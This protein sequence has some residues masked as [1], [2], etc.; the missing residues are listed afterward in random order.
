MKKILTA[1]SFVCLAVALAYGG[2][3]H[4]VGGQARRQHDLLIEQINRSNY[5]YVSTK[6]Y[7]RG[8]FSSTAVTTVTVA[9][10]TRGDPIKFN[11]INS[12]Q[13]G[14]L[15]YLESPHIKGGVQRVVAVIRTRLAPGDRS[16]P[17][18][19]LLEKIPDLEF[20]EVL[21][22]IFYDGSGESY[23]DVPSFRKTLSNDKGADV[24]VEWGGFTSKS[25]FDASLGE[26]SGSYSAPYCQLIEKNRELHVKDIQCDFNSHPGIKGISV[27]SMALSIGS[28]DAAGEGSPPFNLKSFGMQA[29]SG[30]SGQT[31][32]GALRL[33]FDKLNASGLGL[34]PFTVEFEA[35]KLD[36]D[37]LSRFERL[38]Q[39]LRK[40]DDGQAHDDKE[41]LDLLVR[42]ILGDLLAKSPEFEIKQLKVRTDKG[43]MSGRAG[44]AFNGHG[45]NSAVNIPALLGRIDASADLTVSEALFFLIA[46]NALRDGSAPH[47]EAEA[48]SRVS[49][50]VNGL[51]AAKIIVR[52]DGAFKSSATYRDGILTVN[53]HKLDLSKLL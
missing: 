24:D 2:V 25:K 49:G 53:G 42:D 18:K 5:L 9:P 28:I 16:D 52:E 22:V 6:S 41:S 36:A 17:L 37:V 10:S 20:S 44:L 21:T 19:K 33:G 38:A 39:E 14:P 45:E 7:E 46:E 15:V 8:I 40:K 31:I 43:D 47:P 48:K 34:G 32:N 13:H 11:M 12:I 26:V 23:I 29:E 30:V 3:S 51:I 50:L 4:W 35:R 1:L 27:G